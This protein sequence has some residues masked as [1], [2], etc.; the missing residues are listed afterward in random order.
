MLSNGISVNHVIAHWIKNTKNSLLHNA[1]FRV[2][3]QLGNQNLE[4]KVKICIVVYR[5]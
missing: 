3:I 1:L 5:T 2:R 4:V